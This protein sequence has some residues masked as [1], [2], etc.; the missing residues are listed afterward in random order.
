MFR[1]LRRDPEQLNK[2]LGWLVNKRETPAHEDETVSE[3]SDEGE[4]GE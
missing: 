3:S 1:N 2:K 4:E